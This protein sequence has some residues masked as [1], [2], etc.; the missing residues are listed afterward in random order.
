MSEV[1]APLHAGLQVLA[2]CFGEEKPDLRHDPRIDLHLEMFATRMI[3][4]RSSAKVIQSLIAPRLVGSSASR[5]VR[6]SA[7]RD[8][9]SALSTD[10]DRGMGLKN[11]LSGLGM[12]PFMQDVSYPAPVR[13]VNESLMQI[14]SDLVIIQ[15]IQHNPRRNLT[16]TLLPSLLTRTLS[17]AILSQTRTQ[18]P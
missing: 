12:L 6:S 17:L 13:A 8:D 1:R 7:I 4:V 15:Q 3:I 9:P 11:R 18:Q 5:S 2:D 14:Q 16:L 10:S